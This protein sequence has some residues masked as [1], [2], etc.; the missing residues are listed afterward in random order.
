[1]SKEYIER[2]TLFDIIRFTDA[3]MHEVDINEN[4]TY[5]FC[6]E[7]ILEMLNE[8]PAADVEPVRH[9]KWE[10]IDYRNNGENITATCSNCRTRGKVRTNRNCFGMWYIDSPRCPCCGAKM[11]KE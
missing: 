8:I 9:G 11:D 2:E 6:R 3:D 10:F 5:G 1:M 4:H 7:T